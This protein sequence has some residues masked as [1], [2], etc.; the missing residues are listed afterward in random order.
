MR[1]LTFLIENWVNAILN[2]RL[3]ELVRHFLKLGLVCDVYSLGLSLQRNPLPRFFRPAV[4]KHEG[5]PVKL[6]PSVN[7]P[8]RRATLLVNCLSAAFLS[9]GVLVIKHPAVARIL[10]SMG[11]NYILD[12]EDVL[13]LFYASRKLVRDYYSAWK[14]ERIVFKGADLVV[15]ENEYLAKYISNLSDGVEVAVI[16]NGVELELFSPHAVNAKSL[17]SGERVSLGFVGKSLSSQRTELFFRSLRYLPKKVLENVEIILVGPFDSSVLG[18][19]KKHVAHVNIV[20]HVS[21]FE[22]PRFIGN[23]DICL[24]PIVDVHFSRSTKNLEY[25]AMG[26]PT[27]ATDV[28]SNSFVKENNCGIVC[29]LS[30]ED[31]AKG[32]ETL[33]Y[34]QN[35]AVD[36]AKNGLR[37]V[38][39][40]DWNVLARK[41]KSLIEK[42]GLI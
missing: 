35:M 41:Y 3:F 23:M 27:V 38:R 1:H 22:V 18:L 40:Y 29:K 13:S 26:R 21:H 4:A 16:P 14:L 25:A 5:I 10:H 42:K 34:D 12:Y 32:I 15:T 30:P 20:G 36:L 19:L 17:F 11:R 7:L 37:A 33:V 9:E 24:N 2:V 31:F 39:D 28:P 6:I 8:S